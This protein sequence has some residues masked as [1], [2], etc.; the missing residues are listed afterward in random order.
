M[1]IKKS[2]KVAQELVEIKKQEEKELHSSFINLFKIFWEAPKI[3]DEF[4]LNERL[5]VPEYL[6]KSL[7]HLKHLFELSEVGSNYKL[8]FLNYFL[9]LPETEL[10]STLGVHPVSNLEISNDFKFLTPERVRERMKKIKYEGDPDL[11]P[12]RST[13]IT[14]LVR[15]F[16]QLSMYLNENVGLISSFFFCNIFVSVSTEMLS[17]VL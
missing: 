7:E 5:K 12:I 8:F 14:F 9:Q 11:H 15:M 4:S 2:I 16:Y 6:D 3:T 1:Q 13:E 10:D 17:V